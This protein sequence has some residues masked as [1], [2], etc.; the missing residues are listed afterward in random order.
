[1]AVDLQSIFESRIAAASARSMEHADGAMARQ[2]DGAAY[3]MRALGAVITSE[4]V[5]SDD[6]MGMAGL[7]TGIRTPLTITQPGNVKSA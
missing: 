7:N 5:Q 2:T 6:P 3:D 1:V 4:L